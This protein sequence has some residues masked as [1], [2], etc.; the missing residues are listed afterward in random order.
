MA[1]LYIGVGKEQML[2]NYVLSGPVM[3]DNVLCS[4]AFQGQHDVLMCYCKWEC[5]D[6]KTK[7]Q[8]SL[9][10]LNWEVESLPLES[11]GL[12]LPQ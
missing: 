8:N 7:S 3:N 11:G 1:G 2:N 10:F 4:E 12:C 6:F 5:G 9:V